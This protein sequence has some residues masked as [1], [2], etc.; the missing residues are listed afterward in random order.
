MMISR[1]P[2][3]KE[4]CPK[5][6]RLAS[7]MSFTESWL[8]SGSELGWFTLDPEVLDPDPCLLELEERALLLSELL[9]NELLLEA[10]LAR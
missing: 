2:G 4:V 6:S 8:P 7:S 9:V 1:W 5:T 3:R 10:A